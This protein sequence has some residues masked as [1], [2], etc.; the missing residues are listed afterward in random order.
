L[1]G[2]LPSRDDNAS[3]GEPAARGAHPGDAAGRAWERD[4]VLELR[5]RG[6]PW[7]HIARQLGRPLQ[8]LKTTY[9][10]LAVVA[11]P[12]SPA[13]PQKRKP[14]PRGYFRML[15]LRSV[16][17]APGLSASALGDRID[18]TASRVA[19]HLTRLKQLGLARNVSQHPAAGGQWV[20]T[21]EGRVALS[22]IHAGAE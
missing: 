15:V 22:A 12:P 3:W 20:I 13:A 14:V 10:R 8:T 18:T 6:T 5:R 11:P 7:L 9:G 2:A 1:P 21:D 17:A 4:R 19:F 16:A